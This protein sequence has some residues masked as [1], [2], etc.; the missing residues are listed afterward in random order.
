[1]KRYIL[2][3]AKEGAAVVQGLV[4]EGRAIDGDQ[5]FFF[6]EVSPLQGSCVLAK[7]EGLL[8]SLLTR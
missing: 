2:L 1:M 6:H 5:D 4:R 8:I 3:G 7:G